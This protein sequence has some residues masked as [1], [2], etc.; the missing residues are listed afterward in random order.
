MGQKA[1]DQY[2]VEPLASVEKDPV[3]ANPAVVL[4]ETVKTVKEAIEKAGDK[5]RTD[6]GG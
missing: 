1:F 5:V 4:I 6:L 2:F 3:G